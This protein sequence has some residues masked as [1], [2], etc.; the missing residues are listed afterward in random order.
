M[1]LYKNVFRNII[2]SVCVV[3]TSA[4]YGAQAYPQK[5]IKI[6][7]PYQPGSAVDTTSRK[8]AD[9]LSKRLDQPVVVENKTGAFGLIALNSLMSAPADGYTLMVDTPAI[10]I[11]PSVRKVE[12]DPITDIQPIAQ[13]MALPFVVGLSTSVPAKNMK[14]F[15]SYGKQNDGKLN[16]AEGGTSTLLASLLLGMETGVNMQTISYKG[17]A[18][19]VMA[20]LQNECQVIAIDLANLAPHIKAGKMT[21]LLITGDKRSPMLPDVP[22][23]KEVGLDQFNVSTWFGLFGRKG[24]PTEILDKLNVVIGE[25]FNDPDY[26]EYVEGRGANLNPY[27]VKEFTEFFNNDV[28]TWA[29]IV[30]DSGVTFEQ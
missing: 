10:A 21:G 1:K 4:A 9:Q 5:P 27:S 8:I 30:K 19:A 24:T 14:E 11:N 3:G 2:L 17:A 12:Y 13:L 7:V 15:I 16:I 25:I 23:A 20:V 29:R 22:T 26:K 6:I 18:P 28:K